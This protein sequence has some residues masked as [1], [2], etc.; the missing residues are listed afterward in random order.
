MANQLASPCRREGHIVGTVLLVEDE[1]LIR[2][3]ME[4]ALGDVGVPYV[5]ASNGEEAQALLGRVRPKVLVTDIN[6]GPGPNGFALARR[7]RELDPRMEVIYVT[8]HASHLGHEG[9]P[10]ARMVAKPFDPSTLAL[11]VAAL[12]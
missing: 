2:V 5:G 9:V 11:E 6:L 4:D 7:A 12:L 10:G 3:L 8:G 1:A